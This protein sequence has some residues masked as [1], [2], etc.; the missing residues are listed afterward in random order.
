MPVGQRGLKGHAHEKV[1][2]ISPY[3]IVLGHNQEQ[4]LAFKVFF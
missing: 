4:Q 2:K 3:G 1:D